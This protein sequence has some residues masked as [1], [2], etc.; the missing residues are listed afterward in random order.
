MPPC[1]AR[2]R[3]SAAAS[4]PLSAN[5]C[6]TAGVA[7][8][9]AA[10]CA[11]AARCAD[12]RASVGCANRSLGASISCCARALATICSARMES[13]PSAKKSASRSISS[14][15]RISRQRVRSV[16]SMAAVASA[17]AAPA[18]SAAANA[19]GVGW[20]NSSL[21]V[22]ARPAWRACA[23]SCSPR[24]ESPPKA[25]KLSSAL[26]ASRPST[27]AHRRA[28]VASVSSCGVA[29]TGAAT[30]SGTGGKALRSTLPLRSRAKASHCTKAA[31]SIGAGS[32][33]AMAVRSAVRSKPSAGTR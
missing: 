4:R 28:S 11:R 7:A 16:C 6:A 21:G 32:A 29:R 18:R 26:T 14:R 23:T 15:C 25:K 13:P 2:R 22:S 9:A 1:A 33:A 20:A 3:S 5:G 12:R 17:G 30:S 8:G 27:L 19:E 24:M 10:G 31:G